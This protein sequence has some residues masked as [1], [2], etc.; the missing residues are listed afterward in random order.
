MKIKNPNGR[1]VKD[2]G[3]T[4]K[5]CQH[6]DVLVLG[7]GLAGLGAA[8]KLKKAGL[9]FVVLEGQD[10]AGGRVNTMEMSSFNVKTECDTSAKIDTGAQ[11]LH[12][13]YNYLHDVAERHNL[14]SNE[15]SEEGLG[16]FMRDD[17]IVFDEFL[18]KK[19]D[20]FVGQILTE[21]EKYAQENC[22]S[23]PESVKSFLDE[24]FKKY[25]Q[26]IEDAEERSKVEQ[27]FDWHIRFQVID[28]SC[29][30]LDH[31]SAKAWGKYSYNGESCQA[32]YNFRN[33]F[34]SAIDA[35]IG[36]LCESNFHF[37]KEIC[38]IIPIF[39]ANNQS[40]SSHNSSLT[41]CSSKCTASKISVKCSDSTVYYANHVVVTFSLGSLKSNLDTMFIP[42]L[43]LKTVQ[44]IRDIGFETINKLFLQFDTAWWGHLDG[45]QLMFKNNSYKV[46]AVQT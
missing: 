46:R 42:S 10:K 36:E 41:N 8:T 21:C 18:V 29:V 28:N 43:P 15:Q 33:G 17:C 2:G 31:V 22:K 23:Y 39:L 26:T 12:G 45:I 7:A 1:S 6:F 14:L 4:T 13:K 25:A 44:T 11:W 38:E 30:T 24:N 40:S 19:I 3:A 16:A 9:S 32:H 5:E 34:S 20:F 35:L 37:G 27:L